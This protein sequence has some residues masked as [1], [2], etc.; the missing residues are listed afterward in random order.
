MTLVKF[1]RPRLPWYDSMFSDLLGTDR[2]LTDDFFMESRRW[3]PSM[4]VKE[5]KK[6]FEIDIAAPGF[7]KKDF[8]VSIDNGILEI[9]AENKKEMEKKTEDFTRREYNYSSFQRSFTLPENVNE[10]EEI[11]AT[12]KN[13]ILKLVLNKLKEV[14]ITPKKVIEV[15]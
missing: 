13:G 9:S 15:H 12:Y 11:D 1:K 10:K 6:T 14:E 2:L 7:D 4:N 3:I 5:T 8:N